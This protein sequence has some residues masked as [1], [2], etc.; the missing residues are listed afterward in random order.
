M[1][2][3]LEN[4]CQSCKKSDN[5]WGKYTSR[6]ISPIYVSS[7]RQQYHYMYQIKMFTNMDLCV[8]SLEISIAAC[9]SLS[10]SSCL[11]ILG[12]C[13]ARLGLAISAHSATLGNI[14]VCHLNWNIPPTLILSFAARFGASRKTPPELPNNPGI[15]LSL[16]GLGQGQA[17]A[18][19]APPTTTT[20]TA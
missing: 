1:Q 2:K 8:S 17:V 20:T 6:A 14:I 15:S 12:K 5:I 9:S 13:L 18:L 19:A 10:H 16:V 7:L 11:A 4:R 3:V